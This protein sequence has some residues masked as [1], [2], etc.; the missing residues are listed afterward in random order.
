MITIVVTVMENTSCKVT[1][2]YLYEGPDNEVTRKKAEKGFIR[3]IEEI[4]GKLNVDQIEYYLEQYYY[5]GAYYTVCLVD[6]PEV[7]L[8]TAQ[9][10]RVRKEKEK[11]KEKVE[12]LKKEKK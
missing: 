12:K 10:K 3:Q 1:E 2:C 4:Q 7:H 5:P 9:E 6:S 8:E 11:E